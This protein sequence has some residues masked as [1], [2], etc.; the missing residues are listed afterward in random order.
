MK[1]PAAFAAFLVLL[2]SCETLDMPH[3]VGHA[4]APRANWHCA[5]G[6]SFSAHIGT[7]GAQVNAG[8]RSYDL[9]HV[10]GGP[11]MHFGAGGVEY[12]E[13]AGGAS[14]TG[15]AGGPYENCRH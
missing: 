13:L 6:R 14:L 10:A 12:R 2:A 8:G 9:P 7:E 11:G 1:H 5:S 3:S 4:V 15:A